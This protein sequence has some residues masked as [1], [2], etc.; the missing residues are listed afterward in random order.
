MEKKSI[1]KNIVFALL[2]ISVSYYTWKFFS[3]GKSWSNETA[4]TVPV[5]AM[6]IETTKTSFNLELPG[7]IAAFNSSEVRPQVNGII[8]ERLFEE[9]SKVTN[10][11]Q[12]YQIDPTVYEEAYTRAKANFQRAEANLKYLDLKIKRYDKLIKNNAISQQAYDD[13]QVA[14]NQ[15]QAET[16]IY[17]TEIAQAKTNL[18]Y[19]KV[20][21]PISGH[22]G[23]SS[24]TKGA[25]VTANQSEA[26]AKI[27]QLEPVYVDMT[28]SS[29]KLIQFKSQL[30]NTENIPVVL[31][32]NSFNSNDNQYPIEGKLQFSDVNVNPSTGSV[33]LRAIFPNPE[34]I[35]LPGMFVRAKINFA[36]SD[37]ILVPQKAAIRTPDGNLNVWVIDGENKVHPTPITINNSIGNK[38]IVSSGLKVGDKIILEGFQ[39]IFPGATVNPEFIAQDMNDDNSKE[40]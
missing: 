31:F 15:A 16:N 33:L 38:W 8:I 18:D 13:T 24:I 35:L 6:T 34:E 19:T 30:K 22:I 23:K 10:G 37:Y 4:R 5:T 1:I 14:Y 29:N 28:L 20:Y 12:L 27:T 26:L 3:N 32:F 39:K 9:G 25:L 7:R 2:I 11:Q 36:E 17:K 40:Q 21:A